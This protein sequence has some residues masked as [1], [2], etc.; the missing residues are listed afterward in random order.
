L[1]AAAEKGVACVSFSSGL[2]AALAVF[3]S[4][5]SGDH[6]I[7]PD[8]SYF[9]V[10]NIIEKLFPGFG[11]TYSLCDMSDIQATESAIQ[12]STRLI[13]IETPSNPGMKLTD[14]HSMIELAKK[15]NCFTVADNTLATPYYSNPL[16]YGVDIVLHST[17]KYLGGH[18]DLLGGAL[19]FREKN[20]RFEFINQFQKTGG[21]VPSPFD[22]WLLCRSLATFSA[23][24]PIHSSNAMKLAKYLE[25]HPKI[26]K[27]MYPG[28]KS[29]A[30]Y[31]LASKQMNG[32]YGGMLSILV[33]GCRAEALKL[34]SFLNIFRHATSLGGV[35]SLIEHR[36]S[37]EGEQAWSPDNLLRISVGIESADDLIEDFEQALKQV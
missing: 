15:H 6:V 29:F 2:S 22:C 7:L 5:R 20:E 13:W 35:E 28:L 25:Q 3:Q 33:K 34:C 1:L 26:E 23:R 10:R 14:I 4:L 11:L 32:G 27:V 24:M 17:T 18:S 37:V 21:A 31:E 16:Q 19:I 9:G 30:Q 12:P 36:R 8:D